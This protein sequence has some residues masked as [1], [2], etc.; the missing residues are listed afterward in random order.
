MRV[1]HFL[2]G[3][4][5]LALF[6][7]L[8][9]DAQ[10]MTVAPTGTTGLDVHLSTSS[11]NYTFFPGAPSLWGQL[12]AGGY[13]EFTLSASPGT[14]TIQTYYSNGTSTNGTVVVEVNG[15]SQSS[16]AIPSTGSWSNFQMSGLGT[17]SLPSGQSKLR[18]AAPNPPQPYNL[19]GITL[20]PVSL[21]A[22]TSSVASSVLNPLL[23][24]SFYVDPYSL[25]AKNAYLGCLSGQCIS[26]IAAQAQGVWFGDWNTN[27]R[28]DAATV[29]ASAA[30]TGTVP[31]LV[32]YDILYRDCGGYSSGGAQSFAAYETWIQSLAMGIGNGKAVL[33]LEPDA[34]TQYNTAGCLSD[35]QKNQR[36]SLFQYAISQLNQYAPNT[37]VYFDA[38]PPH[39]IDP[40]LI[41]Q[42]LV[43]AGVDRAAGFAV[44]V[45]NYE[46]TADSITYGNQ[47]SAVA[48]GK[49]FVIDTSRNGQGPTADHEYCNPPNR[50]LGLPS[51]AIS[52]GLVDAYLWVQNPGTSD[53]TC[54]GFPPAGTFSSA[55]AWT[56]LLNS[57]F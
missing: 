26:K 34:L 1:F 57:S 7:T 39:G 24:S 46:S 37:A 40:V 16:L 32:A 27:P 36:L 31:I 43:Y 10:V 3:I 15:T 14:Y 50:G 28:A 52:G 4:F 48:G 12:G 20:T 25:A 11:Y 30:S 41:G 53:G 44:N 45:S 5:L 56:L 47:V 8:T 55:L 22:V 23:G 38:G 19:A 13:V 21:L 2:R 17:V 35:D 42:T 54:N 6:S 51:R 18:L 33:I 49:H 9:I 29:M